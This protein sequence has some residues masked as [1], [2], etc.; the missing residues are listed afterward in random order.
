MKTLKTLFATL[1]IALS[2]TSCGNPYAEANEKLKL[3]MEI[4]DEYNEQMDEIRKV[5]L[6]LELNEIKNKQ[7][8]LDAE[9]ALIMNR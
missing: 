2:I 8:V 5:Q 1:V 6:D 4:Q 3:E 9:A 7:A